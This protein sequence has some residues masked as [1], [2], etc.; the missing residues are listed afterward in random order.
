MFGYVSKNGNY[1]T[2]NLTH[3]LA[4]PNNPITKTELKYNFYYGNEQTEVYNGDKSSFDIS[5]IRAA[6][7]NVSIKVYVTYADGVSDLVLNTSYNYQP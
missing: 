3:S 4:N 6:Y 1:L 5:T 2:I 7:G